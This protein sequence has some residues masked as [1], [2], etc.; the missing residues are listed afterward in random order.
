M[1][2]DQTTP[3]A[4]ATVDAPA[5]E[6]ALPEPKRSMAWEPGVE[7]TATFKEI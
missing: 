2:V 1:V 5:E 4:E 3:I 6:E 7:T